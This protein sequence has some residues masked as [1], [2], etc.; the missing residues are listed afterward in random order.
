MGGTGGVPIP[1]PVGAA[2]AAA[3]PSAVSSSSGSEPI[4]PDGDVAAVV[5][6]GPIVA[7][8]VPGIPPVAA[9]E[10]ICGKDTRL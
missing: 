1:F 9:G 7:Y 2:A 10:V 6:R 8:I 4:S 3:W 5:P